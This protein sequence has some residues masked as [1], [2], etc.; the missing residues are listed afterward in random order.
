MS[1]PDQT[2]RLAV[3][4]FGQTFMIGVLLGALILSG[5]IWLNTGSVIQVD[6]FGA[7]AALWLSGQVAVLVHHL[8]PALSNS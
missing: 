5:T 3:L 8:L 7:I 6:G 1:F 2:W 4:A